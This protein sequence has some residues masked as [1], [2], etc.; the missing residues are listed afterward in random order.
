M[1]RLP[2]GPTHRKA[3]DGSPDRYQTE[4]LGDSRKLKQTHERPHNPDTHGKNRTQRIP[5]RTPGSRLFSE[6]LMRM[7]TTNCE[8]CYPLLPGPRR[9]TTGTIYDRRYSRLLENARNQPGRE[10][11]GNLPSTDWPSVRRRVLGKKM[12]NCLFRRDC[13]WRE[14]TSIYSWCT[15]CFGGDAPS[16]HCRRPAR[17]VN[18]AQL[19]PWT[20]PC[21]PC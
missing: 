19:A 21:S 6:I 14:R 17:P 12:L 5:C 4:P 15:P 1:D 11:R 16:P 13:L 3:E 7:V 20:T 10:G 9:P 18:D 2:S 8:T